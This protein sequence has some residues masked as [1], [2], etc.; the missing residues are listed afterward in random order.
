MSFSEDIALDTTIAVADVRDPANRNSQYTKTVVIPGNADIIKQLEFI[1]DVNSTLVV[2]NPNKKIPA[3]YEVD[4]STPFEG[5]LQLK[6]ITERYDGTNKQLLFNCTITGN[7]MDLFLSL[8]NK[9]LTDINMADLNHQLGY[10]A[11]S[12]SPTLGVGYCYGY[13]D[14]GM[15]G[16]NGFNWRVDHM[17]AAIFALEY[18]K[19]IFTAAGFTFTSSFLNSTYFKS[20]AIPDVNEGAYQFLP[21]QIASYQ[22]YAHKNS[23][24]TLGP[25]AGVITAGGKYSFHC[26][27]L[28]PI[29]FTDDS[30]PPF[31]DPGGIYNTGT[32][33]YTAAVGNAQTVTFTFNYTITLTTI[34][35]TVTF[36]NPVNPALPVISVQ[37]DILKNGVAIGGVQ[38]QLID[39][40]LFT[41][42]GGIATYSGSF[43]VTVNTGTIVPGDVFQ[44][45]FNFSN[46]VGY[47][48][49]AGGAPIST[50]TPSNMSFAI[51][52]GTFYN[53]LSNTNLMFG[54]T[55][56]MNTTIPPLV[57]QADFLKWLILAFNL[58]LEQDKA[59]PKNYIIEPR[60]QFISTNLATALKWTYKQDLSRD[61]ETLPMGALDGRSYLF[62]YAEDKDYFNQ[63]YQDK[64]KETYGQQLIKID[65]DFIKTDKTIQLGF[66][67]TPGVAFQTDIVAPRFLS[68]DGAYPGTGGGGTVK[69]LQCN[70]RILYYGGMKNCNV[71][72]LTISPGT[73]ILRSQ[74]PSLNHVDDPNNPTKDLS[75]NAPREIYWQLPAQLW[76][77]DDLY[78][79][80]Y[81][82]LINAIADPNS[83]IRKSYF[84]LTARDIQLFSFRN[85]VHVE[86]AYY[87]VNYITQYDPTKKQSVLVEMLKLQEG[88]GL[89]PETYDPNDNPTGQYRTI[90]TQPEYNGQ[91]NYGQTGNLV[92]GIGLT[93][94]AEYGMLTGNN[95]HVDRAVKS[96]D[97]IGVTNQIITIDLEGQVMLRADAF[98]VSDNGIEKVKMSRDA[99]YIAN[100]TV[101][102]PISYVNA[103][104]G[105]I[106][107]KLPSVHDLVE[108]I[109]I[110]T[111]TSGNTVT[112]TGLAGTELIQS[113]G[114]SGVTDSVPNTTKRNY[115]TNGTDWFY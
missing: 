17:K 88:P 44:S 2:F 8:T 83:K 101:T 100:F 115:S 10:S 102:K 109:V 97:G 56:L 15:A 72:H 23:T 62:K 4:G 69:P 106:T 27:G 78:N 38:T 50:G 99:E 36:R 64:W 71:H 81:R 25:F 41:I 92:A 22:F 6:S 34:A 82:K 30:T 45:S 67:P 76:T 19:R 60:D 59:N 1:F 70:I 3:R 24:T 105:N 31:N 58:Y 90:Q 74:Y 14:Y 40:N 96:F 42:G 75:F 18:V 66:S 73:T 48:V 53:N 80:F 35:G 54:D 12:A 63:R 33:E 49:D 79:R 43:N 95:S 110:R 20:L 9:Y 85:I 28:N 87:L 65:N 21:I 61:I 89:T 98:R 13:I 39:G 37:L 26:S 51:T 84:L 47:F 5:Q 111:D 46:V 16:L 32:G 103:T 112:V 7:N 94:G 108:C 11:F 86:N 68:I 114:V 55:I 107:V 29:V 77:T 113:S 91:G 57:L 104:S 52:G 93:N